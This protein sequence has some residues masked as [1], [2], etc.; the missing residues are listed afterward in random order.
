MS[1]G[2][3]RT[4][5][6]DP[7]PHKVCADKPQVSETSRLHFLRNRHFSPRAI[8]FR[9]TGLRLASGLSLANTLTGGGG[10]AR[11]QFRRG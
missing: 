6:H 5:F 11:G 1:R 4:Q 7:L 9:G 3:V 2:G 8:H 10:V